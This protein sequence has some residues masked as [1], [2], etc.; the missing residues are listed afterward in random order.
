[1]LVFLL[2]RSFPAV[3]LLTWALAMYLTWVELREQQTRFRVKLWWYQ[4]TFL[5]HF[6]GYLILRAWVFYRRRKATA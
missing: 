4:L 6:V 5:F 2:L 1:M 3:L